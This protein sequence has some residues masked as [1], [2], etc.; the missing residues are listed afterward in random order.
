MTAPVRLSVLGPVTVRA[1]GVPV[2]LGSGKVLALLALLAADRSRAWQDDAVRSALWGDEPPGDPCH[3]TAAL[4]VHVSELRHR[5]A[6]A[7][8]AV[9]RVGDGYRL[10]PGPGCIDIDLVRAHV[11]RGDAATR[12]GDHQ[13]AS[14]E[15]ALALGTWTG[16]PLEGVTAPYATA[17]RESLQY[18]HRAI[19]QNRLESDLRLGLGALHLEEAR[20]L[21]MLDRYDERACRHR[22]TALMQAERRAEALEVYAAFRRRL[23]RA[24]GIEPGPELAAAHARALVGR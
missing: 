10:E 1:G 4:R 3:M 17:L 8:V 15:Y 18:W 9:A 23:V 12:F 19:R 11:A 7:R 20:Q 24:L 2:S 6:P 14:R 13:H 22:M 5:L 21:C 16:E